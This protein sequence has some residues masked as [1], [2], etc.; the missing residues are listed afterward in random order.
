TA[1]RVLRGEAA[2]VRDALVGCD[3][4]GARRR[5]PALVGRDA[6]ELDASGIAAATIE[7]LAE[8]LVDAVVAPALWAVAFGAIG[9]GAYRAVNTMDAMVGHHSARYERFGWASARVDDIAGYVPA[10]VMALLVCLA[11]P[12]RAREVFAA[13]RED[14]GAHPSPNAGVAEAAFAGALGLELG[15]TVRYGDAVEHRPTL[16]SG[17]R[18][19]PHDIERAIRLADRVELVLAGVLVASGLLARRRPR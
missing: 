15:G 16:G 9:A 5:L 18:P 11:R 7:S 19:T 10:R 6:T 4:D 3:I 13:V 1:G 17:P 8:N 14:A 2:G 12:G